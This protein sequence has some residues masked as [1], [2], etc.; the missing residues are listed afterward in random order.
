MV[1]RYRSFLWAVPFIL[2]C[3]LRRADQVSE[4]LRLDQIG[5]SAR[6]AL[7]GPPADSIQVT[8]VAVNESSHDRM[9]EIS[10]C[11]PRPVT[12]LARHANKTWNSR[13]WERS[14]APVYRDSAGHILPTISMCYIV[15]G[16]V[17][18]G[19]T[20]SYDDRI[21]VRDILGDSLPPGRYKSTARLYINRQE[22][23]ALSAGEI[24]LHLPHS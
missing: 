22:A 18:P 16:Q 14:K 1:D 11:P 3:H 6:S 2:G 8:V 24:E 9:M 17:S 19:G 4:G 23:K 20:R 5:F 15:G 12:I 10:G 13:V 21:S 7:V